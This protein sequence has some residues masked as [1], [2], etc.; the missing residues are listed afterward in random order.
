MFHIHVL[1]RALYKGELK[2]DLKRGAKKRSGEPGEVPGRPSKMHTQFPLIGKKRS[3]AQDKDVR[4]SKMHTQFP[5]IGKKRTHAQDKDTEWKQIKLFHSAAVKRKGAFS[6]YLTEKKSKRGGKK[7][8]GDEMEYLAASKRRRR[9]PSPPPKSIAAKRRMEEAELD[10]LLN[11]PFAYLPPS[12]KKSNLRATGVRSVGQF[13]RVKRKHQD[14]MDEDEEEEYT[15]VPFK[16]SRI[17]SLPKPRRRV[18]KRKFPDYE[19]LEEEEEYTGVPFKS[20]R[21]TYDYE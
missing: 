16:T 12:A 2:S 5:L 17:S 11:D 20:S 8:S 9:G 18:G 13:A 3:H 7:R 15:G 10:A 6:Q 14:Y 1:K 4:P 21:V 19:D